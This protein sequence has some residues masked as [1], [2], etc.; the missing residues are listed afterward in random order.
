MPACICGHHVLI[1]VS[2]N[3]TCV[4]VRPRARVCVCVCLC[5][6]VFDAFVG[7]DTESQELRRLS[8]RVISAPPSDLYKLDT[9]SRY[10]SRNRSWTGEPPT[11]A[12]TAA[13]SAGARPHTPGAAAGAILSTYNNVTSLVLARLRDGSA[14]GASPIV[15]TTAADYRR[16]SGRVYTG[17][18]DMSPGTSPDELGPQ[19]AHGLE[20]YSVTSNVLRNFESAYGPRGEIEPEG[21]YFDNNVHGGRRVSPLRHMAGRREGLLRGSTPPPIMHGRR[22]VVHMS[23]DNNAL[24]GGDLP[25]GLGFNALVYTPVV[26]ALIGARRGVGVTARQRPSWTKPAAAAAAAA[27]TSPSNLEIYEPSFHPTGVPPVSVSART[28]SMASAQGGPA[29]V[30]TVRTSVGTAHG[31][32]DEDEFYSCPSSPVHSSGAQAQSHAQLSVDAHV[33][34]VEHDTV[35]SSM[36]VDMSNEGAT[37]ELMHAARTVRTWLPC[38]HFSTGYANLCA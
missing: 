20:E 4:C 5:A 37:G 28:G 34:A 10:R 26:S 29:A 17:G 14:A 24:A 30:G 32:E 22:H 16:L 23:L 3:L 31:A 19:L 8:G 33:A 38:S 27:A 9:P 11:S 13:T 21:V 6:Q 36:D 25:A 2:P 1:F 7:D 35:D 15:S 18:D 12:G